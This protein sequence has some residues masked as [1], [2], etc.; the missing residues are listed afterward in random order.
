MTQLTVAFRDFVKA[1]KKD[2]F[3]NANLQKSKPFAVTLRGE[4]TFSFCTGA[5]VSNSGWTEGHN[6]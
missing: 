5:D 2:I 1:L 6:R 4:C 3:E